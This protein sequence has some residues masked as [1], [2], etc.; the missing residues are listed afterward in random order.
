MWYVYAGYLVLRA[1]PIGRERKGLVCAAVGVVAFLDVPLVFFATTLWGGVHPQDTARK[2]SGMT[3]EM[4]ADRGRGPRGHGPVVG[5][6]AHP[7]LAASAAPRTPCLRPSPGNWNRNT[8]E[9]GI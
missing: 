2:A 6:P 4:C 5:L 7:A 8:L 9:D 3:G 1:A